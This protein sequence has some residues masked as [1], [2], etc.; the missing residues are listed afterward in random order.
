M[1]R[2]PFLSSLFF[3][4]L[5]FCLLNNPIGSLPPLG[6]VLAP[7]VG[8]WQNEGDEDVS[9]NAAL[10]GLLQPVEVYY[11]DQYI[12]HIF[13]KSDRDLYFAQGYITAKHRLWQMEFQTHASAGRLS[14]IFGEKALEY[15]RMQRRKGMVFGAENTL[16]DMLD[17]PETAA[18]LRAYTAGVNAYIRSLNTAACPVEYKLLD[19]KPEAWT[20][21]KTALLLMYMTDMLCGGDFDLEYTNALRLYGKERFDQWF[22]D[23][24]DT[25]DPVISKGTSWKHIRGVQTNPPKTSFLL[26]TISETFEKP[27]PNNGSNNWAIAP[28]KSNSGHAILANDPHLKLN[29][30]SIWFVMQLATPEHNAYGA[31]LPGALGVIS[32]FNKDIAWGETNATRDVKDWYQIHF[33]DAQKTAYRFEG[34]WV[35]TKVRIEKINLK[36]QEAFLDTVCYTHHGPVSYDANFK[37]TDQKKGYAMKWIGHLGGNGQKTFLALNRAK[38]YEDYLAALQH[39]VAPAQNIV[40][41]STTGD[42][43]LWV[44]GDFANKW[45]GQGKFLMDGSVAENDWQSFIPKS[46]NAFSKN[47]PRG[48]VSSAN[49]HPTDQT[50]P[51]YVFNDGYEM[52]RNRIIN[53]FLNANDRLSVADFKALQNNNFNLK[54][55]EILPNML[56]AVDPERLQDKEKRLLTLL[57]NWDFINHKDALAPS[58]FAAWWKQLYR[59]TWDEFELEKI[60]LKKPFVYQSIYLL[61]NHPSGRYADILATSTIETANDLYWISFKQ[62]FKDMDAWRLDKANRWKNEKGT[63]AKH[64]LQGLPAFSHFDLPI[65]GE[66][67]SP[68]AVTED[69]GPSWKMIVEMSSPP[70][71][72]GIYPGGQSGNPGSFYYDNMLEKWAAGEY[73]EAVFMQNET[74]TTKTTSRQLL[75]PKP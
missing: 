24:F 62:A 5:F 29:L 40:F 6:S 2:L 74:D 4:V 68:N 65:G 36:N 37:G 30:P 63:A 49:Q 9:G 38:N 26:D 71:A 64:L 19:Y 23:F 7:S 3:T 50:Y 32:G 17:D 58:L 59:L 41:A 10:D 15:D 39:W 48:F 52:Y 70:K 57:G 56:A 69:H 12:P 11:D 21:L 51:Y 16:K 13:A 28:K 1:I 73:Y 34:K 61:K 46:D 14:E 8:F 42:I 18:L 66:E 47:P 53:D 25:V 45:E 75:H 54:A 20:P 43:A 31:T 35:P 44:Q 72:L 33:Q 27:H 60:A 55:S 22:P 67:N